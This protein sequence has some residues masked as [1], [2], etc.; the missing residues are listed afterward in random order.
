MSEWVSEE[1]AQ[2]GGSSGRYVKS[3]EWPTKAGA[4]VAVIRIL[5]SVFPFFEGWSGGK[6]VR[7]SRMEDFTPGIVWDKDNKFGQEQ[8]RTPRKQW[9]VYAY[10]VERPSEVLWW[11]IGQ[12]GIMEALLALAVSPKG[13][14]TKYDVMVTYKEGKK[15]SPYSVVALDS[16]PVNPEALAAYEA[17]VA[18]GGKPEGCLTSESPFPPAGAAA[19]VVA[20]AEPVIPF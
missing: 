17:L 19:P 5:S 7:A 12:V 16:A 10:Y 1:A 4:K 18:A 8:V 11:Q 3:K 6:P 15:P 2:I 14:P 20:A 9:G 13:A